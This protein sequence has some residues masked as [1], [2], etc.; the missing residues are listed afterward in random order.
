MIAVNTGY[1]IQIDDLG[2]PKGNPL[3]KKGAIY[4]FATL[5]KLASKSV[6]NGIL[7]K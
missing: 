6:E 2:M 5:T 1:E 3:Y 7:L 4:K